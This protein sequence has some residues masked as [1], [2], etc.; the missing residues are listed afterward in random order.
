MVVAAWD[1]GFVSVCAAPWLFPSPTALVQLISFGGAW[2]VQLPWKFGSWG[3][4]L[5]PVDRHGPKHR[6]P[7]PA[8]VLSLL[9]QMYP[10]HP[11]FC[12]G[13]QQAQGCRDAHAARGSGGAPMSPQI[14][15]L[16]DNGNAFPISTQS[17]ANTTQNVL[18]LFLEAVICLL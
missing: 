12:R 11:S 4:Q 3:A 9:F 18:C 8:K 13:T 5:L 6:I 17:L 14:P 10:R 16:P 15:G 7:T 1:V 2:R